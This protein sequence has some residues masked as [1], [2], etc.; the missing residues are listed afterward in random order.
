[1]IAGNSI[2]SRLPSLEARI[3]EFNQVAGEMILDGMLAYGWTKEAICQTETRLRN[4]LR[5]H[6]PGI[7]GVSLS[8]SSGDLAGDVSDEEIVD[9][10]EGLPLAE[11]ELLDSLFGPLPFEADLN[12]PNFLGNEWNT[13]V[14]H[15]PVA[16]FLENDGRFQNNSADLK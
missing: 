11:E 1:V 6:C 13:D 9:F 2:L 8:I 12:I 7:F 10:Q 14:S 4:A 16:S 3:K 15:S 5:R